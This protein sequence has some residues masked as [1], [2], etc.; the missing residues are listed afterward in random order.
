ME[1]KK[2]LFLAT[3]AVCGAMMM[4][5]LVAANQNGNES[6]F[7]THQTKEYGCSAGCTGEYYPSH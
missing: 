7:A 2:A 1:N 3:A 5:V 6:V 4:T